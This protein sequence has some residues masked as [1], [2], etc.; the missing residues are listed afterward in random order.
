M[1]PNAKKS[2][3]DLISWT[4]KRTSIPLVAIG[5]IDDKN[6]KSLLKIGVNYLAISSFIWNNPRLKPKDAIKK[7]KC[8]TIVL[9][10]GFQYLRL[11]GSLN[12][13]LV[14]STN[15]FGNGKL[16]PRGIL[17]EPLHRLSRADYIFLTKSNKPCAEAPIKTYLSLNL[18]PSNLPSKTAL[19]EIY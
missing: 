9:D 18:A 19:A 14:D 4:K 6:F 15:P 12:L 2:R 1:K 8:D 5:G 17:R 11:R 13:C 16:L 7:F 3:K 10:D